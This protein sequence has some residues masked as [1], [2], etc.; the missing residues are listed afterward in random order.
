METEWNGNKWVKYLHPRKFHYLKVN[1]SCSISSLLAFGIL[2]AGYNKNADQTFDK[3]GLIRTR[4][5][6]GMV[7]V[8]TELCAWLSFALRA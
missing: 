7:Y 1:D 2:G 4:A 5:Q 8:H 6:V 3:L